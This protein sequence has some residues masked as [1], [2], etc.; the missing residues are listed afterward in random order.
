MWR[1]AW[2]FL[3]NRLGLGANLSNFG[4]KMTYI[5]EAQ[6]DPLPTNLRLGLAYN[7]LDDDF[8]K[9]TLV[10]DTNRLLVVRDENGSDNVFK[11][12]FY[13][14]WTTGTF[15]ERFRASS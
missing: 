7:L 2:E 14:A 10:Y 15:E 12:V 1:P 5:D 4:P 6:A 13:S 3:G 8:N 11:A 9:I